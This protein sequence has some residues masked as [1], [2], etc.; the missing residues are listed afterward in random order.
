M[1]DVMILQ[2]WNS[3]ICIPLAETI[4]RPRAWPETSSPDFS[5]SGRAGTLR[6]E[7]LHFRIRRVDRRPSKLCLP[8]PLESFDLLDR[9]VRRLQLFCPN[10]LPEH[11]MASR[12]SPGETRRFWIWQPIS[13]AVWNIYHRG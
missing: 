2:A 13:Q 12:G 1:M 11:G 6:R 4:A 8:V 9:A 10:L 5:S 7:G 3:R